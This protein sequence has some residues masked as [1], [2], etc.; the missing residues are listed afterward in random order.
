MG[1]VQLLQGN[2][3][4]SLGALAAGVR[5]FAGYPLPPVRKLPNV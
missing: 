1:K 4:C 2:Q 3:A 5:F